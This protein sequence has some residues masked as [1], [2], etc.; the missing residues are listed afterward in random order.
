M[1]NHP[2]IVSDPHTDSS[3]H[4][5]IGALRM[6]SDARGATVY[7][8]RLGGHGPALSKPCEACEESLRAAGVKRVVWTT[9][10]DCGVER[11]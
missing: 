4:A 9:G 1:R 5:E 11:Y 6:A 2:M 7:V 10:G 8:A 3:T